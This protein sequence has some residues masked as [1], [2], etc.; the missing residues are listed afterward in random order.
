MD[1]TF[2]SNF[3]A[4]CVAKSWCSFPAQG[5]ITKPGIVLTVS[6]SERH[7]IGTFEA[8]DLAGYG[9]FSCPNPDQ[10][11]VLSGGKV[12]I[13]LTNAPGSYLPWCY[14]S[15]SQVVSAAES[16]LLLFATVGCRIVAFGTEPQWETGVLCADDLK[17]LSVSGDY[18]KASGW[19]PS[20]GSTVAF[21][22]DLRNG[23]QL[24]YVWR[25]APD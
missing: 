13:L 22:V 10:L 16:R 25:L 3:A 17:L 20:I 21:R 12:T 4:D 8:G 19:D 7:W 15:V 5:D 18:L 14:E 2:D 1:S 23:A 24:D 11:C 9:I 6:R